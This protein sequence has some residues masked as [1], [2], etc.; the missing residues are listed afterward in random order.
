MKDILFSLIVGLFIVGS[1]L[2][3]PPGN[4]P[5][6]T[7]NDATVGFAVDGDQDGTPDFEVTPSGDVKMAAAVIM[8][9][10]LATTSDTSCYTVMYDSGTASDTSDDVVVGTLC[11]QLSSTSPLT[12]QWTLQ[13][14][15]S[16][17][18]VNQTSLP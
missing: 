14:I 4:T 11:F 3:A 18:L 6:K 1:A 7:T 9:S 2:A 17:S 15:D 16:G 10:P 13:R 12:G 8:G 5:V